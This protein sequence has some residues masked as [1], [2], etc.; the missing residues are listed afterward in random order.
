VTKARRASDIERLLVVTECYPRPAAPGHCA[1]AHRQMIG[2]R[3]AGWAIEVGLPN[4]WY[5]RVGWRLT[6]AW[7]A[8]RAASIPRNWQ[9]DGIVVGDLTFANP[10]PGR[11]FARRAF[12]D[13]IADAIVRRVQ[14]L[15]LTEV[16]A[17]LMAQFALPYGPSVRD[18]ARRLSLP[19]VV[20][21][22]GDDVWVWPHANQRATLEF[23]ETLRDAHL[24]TSVSRSLLTE[25]QRLAGEL[26]H[27]AVVPN[28][29]DLA[30][31]R[32]PASAVERRRCRELL[33]LSRDEVAI[34]CVADAIVRKGWLELLE[35]L[36]AISIATPQ[37]V[38]VAVLA[39]K[40]D[41]IDI[42]AES[43]RRAPRVHVAI[44][45]GVGA[46]RLA[47]FYRAG[48]LFCLASHW[49]GMSNALLEAMASGLP[50][51]ATAVPGHA[52]VITDGFD[53]V[54]VPARNPTALR[55]A[56]VPLLTSADA[57]F[58]MGQAARG[59][60]ESVGTSAKAGIRLA[61]LLRGVTT[62]VIDQEALAADPYAPSTSAV[63]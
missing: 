31:F 16:P 24:V 12:R 36:G 9:L 6:A 52:E 49:E 18:A 55:S 25:A 14:R 13:R 60:A 11:L 41:E 39:N 47:D 5:P 56:L 26:P 43:A 44:H 34:V 28:G 7:R 59:R 63:A 45:R 19:Y 29:I 53:G 58:A 61:A 17:L 32:P 35:A 22:R 21:L 51:V 42:T 57:R 3:G 37:L 1:F 4:G 10:W 33:G 54:L 20:Q 38:L 62:G 48:D 27:A 15:R 2:L 50:C 8:A 30:T 40:V 46:A 23:I